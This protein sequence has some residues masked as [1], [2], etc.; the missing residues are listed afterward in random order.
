LVRD[1]L[2]SGEWVVRDFRHRDEDAIAARFRG[3]VERLAAA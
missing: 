1:V 2:A 3:V